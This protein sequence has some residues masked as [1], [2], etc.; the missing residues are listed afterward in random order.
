[1]AEE[2]ERAIN[3]APREP[4]QKTNRAKEHDPK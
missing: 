1:M 3:P 4:R 2:V